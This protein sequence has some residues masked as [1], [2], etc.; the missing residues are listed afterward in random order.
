MATYP[1]KHKETGE[2][3]D[4]VMSVH[5]WDQWKEDNPDW[6]RYYTPENAPGVGE[7]GEWQDKLICLLYTSPSPRDV[8]ES[9]MPSSA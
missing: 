1:V 8:E 4:V 5:A 6:E 7:V 9:R 2:T 3:K